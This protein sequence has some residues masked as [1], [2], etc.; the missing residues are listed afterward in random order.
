[1]DSLL[2]WA[3][4]EELL[5]GQRNRALDRP[6]RD[7]RDY[8]A[9]GAGDHLLMPGD[10]AQAISDVAEIINQLWG[11]ATPGGRL[12]PAPIHREVQLIGWSARGNVMA[13]QVGLPRDGQALEPQTAVGQIQSALPGG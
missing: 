5:R 7:M 6:L 11:V 2:R 13:G 10:S 9:H 3:R 8:V 1:L 12:Y 4:E